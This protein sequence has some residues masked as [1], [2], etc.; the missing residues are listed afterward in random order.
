MCAYRIHI[1]TEIESAPNRVTNDI[2]F[3]RSARNL[4]KIKLLC[5]AG[6]GAFSLVV[7]CA[8]TVLYANFDHYRGWETHSKQRIR[9]FTPEQCDARRIYNRKAF[10]IVSHSTLNFRIRSKRFIR[11]SR[12]RTKCAPLSN[13][14]N[15]I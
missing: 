8:R 3:N 6:S 11:Q 10:I 13:F 9:T 5:V 4:R 12:T 2:K 1:K 14:T 15:E 7:L